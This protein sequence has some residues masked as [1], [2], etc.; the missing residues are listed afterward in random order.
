MAHVNIEIKAQCIDPDRIRR[1]LEQN[2]ADYKGRDRQIDT[3]FKIPA[4]R[5]KL[6]QGTIENSLIYYDRPDAAGP[7]R[8]DVSLFRTNPTGGKHL[9]ELLTA[10][11]DVWVVVDK[12]RDIYFIDNVK[13]HLDT[14][15]GLGCFVEIEA[16]DET[17]AIGPDKLRAQCEHYMKLFNIAK[18]DLVNVSYSDLLPERNQ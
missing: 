4:G 9:R 17:G 2:G 16:I 8:A 10:A 12:Q 15:E 5:L 11:L 6:R 18:T 7:K 3:Y 14:V 13:F 1:L